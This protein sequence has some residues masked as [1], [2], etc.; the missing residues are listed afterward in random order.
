MFAFRC[1]YSMIHI[2]YEP[3]A[4]A[5]KPQNSPLRPQPATPHRGPSERR[6]GPRCRSDRTSLTSNHWHWR[7]RSCSNS[8]RVCSFSL[9]HSAAFS[10]RSFSALGPLSRAVAPSHQGPPLHF[11]KASSV[12][13]LA[14]A[15]ASAWVRVF[16][17]FGPRTRG[18]WSVGSL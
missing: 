1:T 4:L 2:T 16:G 15:M 17:G 13:Y 11:A 6:S 7:S 14:A 9:A 12:R 3:K 10:P 5:S 8:Y 18:P